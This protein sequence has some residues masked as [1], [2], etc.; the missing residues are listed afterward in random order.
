MKT[1][2]LINVSL[3]ALVALGF[4]GAVKV[5]LANFN[6]VSCPALFAVP[7]CYV[8]TAAYGLMLGSLI[9]NHHGCKHHFFCMGWGTAFVI[10]LMASTVEFFGSG[11]I[12]P[13][14]SGGL[15]A[16]AS[17]IPLCYISLAML[18]IILVLFIKGPYQ[19]VCAAN[20]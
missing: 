20:Q 12:C 18:I 4:I 14:S 15:R 6:G 17:G 11:S 3:W 9:I 1:S 7:I 16:A 2:T 5:S 10:A 8:V 13:S 19:K